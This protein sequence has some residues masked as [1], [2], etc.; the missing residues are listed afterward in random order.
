MLID[1]F[2][3]AVSLAGLVTRRAAAFQWLLECQPFVTNRWF[4][5]LLDQFN[6][7]AYVR[8]FKM[9][10]L[11]PFAENYLYNYGQAGG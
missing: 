9:K 3:A 5:M 2:A 8:D 1:S 7:N 4:M 10:S 6:R 11:Q